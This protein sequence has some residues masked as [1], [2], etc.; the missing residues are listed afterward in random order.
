MASRVSFFRNRRYERLDVP[1]RSAHGDPW[2]SDEV[3]PE[4]FW[5]QNVWM[6]TVSWL[7]VPG[8]GSYYPHLYLALAAEFFFRSFLFVL[9]GI[10]VWSV[11]VELPVYFFLNRFNLLPDNR[12]VWIQFVV[13][14]K[15]NPSPQDI[16]KVLS[17]KLKYEKP[18]HGEYYAVFAGR[19]AGLS[20][21]GHFRAREDMIERAGHNR[22]KEVYGIS[23]HRRDFSIYVL[24]ALVLD[25]LFGLLGAGIAWYARSSFGL[26]SLRDEIDW[27]LGLEFLGLFVII[28]HLAVY[29]GWIFT[30][31]AFGYIFVLGAANMDQDVFEWTPYLVLFGITAYYWV[32]FFRNPVPMCLR[33]PWTDPRRNADAPVLMEEI[34]SVTTTHRREPIMEHHFQHEEGDEE[35]T[36]RRKH[37]TT[38]ESVRETAA[39]EATVDDYSWSWW[40]F[41][42]TSYDTLGY[43]AWFG[44]MTLLIIIAIVALA[45]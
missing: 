22:I 3:Y 27:I 28:A 31:I 37:P 30:P 32:V 44:S 23:Y 35:G 9:L 5:W 20:P 13:Y 12:G 6:A 24:W 7:P 42:A 36:R 14:H 34:S 11:F 2:K 15:K 26:E 21:W 10:F 18:A 40:I 33:S 17:F 19:T 38:P 4:V 43:Q 29:W 45:L 41:S 25:V 39:A 8:I 16:E 1:H